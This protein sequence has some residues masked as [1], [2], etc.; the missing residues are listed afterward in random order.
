M[1]LDFITQDDWDII[2]RYIE[3]LAPLK[4]FTLRLECKGFRASHGVVWQVIPAMEKLL[5]H[6][7]K[8]KVQYSIVEPE[9]DCSVITSQMRTQTQ[10]RLQTQDFETQD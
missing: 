4:Q 8:L 7:E 5:G 2:A 3:I 10:S 1:L 6:L 9:Q